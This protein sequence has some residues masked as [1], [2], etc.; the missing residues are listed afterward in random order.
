[1]KDPHT[2]KK[3]VVFGKYLQFLYFFSKKKAL[4]KAY[5]LFCTPRKGIVLPEQEDLL[6]EAEDEVVLVDNV[7]IQT[8]RWS[9]MGE[10]VLLVHGWESNTFRWRVLIKKLQE[11]GY[12]VIAYDAPAHGHSSGKIFNVPLNAA[13]LQKIIEL[14][15][16]NYIIGH[17]M[18]AMTTIFHQYLY[19]NQ[20]IDKLVMLAPPSELSRM[21]KE[22]QEVLKLSPKFMEALNQYFKDTHGYYF[23]EF[24]AAGFAK[25]LTTKGI[26]IHDKKDKIAPYQEAEA[27]HQNWSN[28][29][30][31]LT[32][33]FGHSLFFAEVDRLILDF[34]EKE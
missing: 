18:G 7:Y 9:G 33:D 17:S 13:C 10:T 6:E 28:G 3:A 11:Q 14:Y 15:R 23:E 34:L 24:S 30:L 16:P 21:I 4:H 27:I 19:G 2:N 20:E 12:N 5:T 22:Y 32:E 8:Y 29:Q 1:M 25:K 26:L 31:V